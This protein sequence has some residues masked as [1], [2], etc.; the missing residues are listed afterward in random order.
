MSSIVCYT[1]AFVTG[2]YMQYPR[3]DRRACQVSD[4]PPSDHV[5]NYDEPWNRSVILDAVGFSGFGNGVGLSSA[6]WWQWPVD[7]SQGARSCAGLIE[8]YTLDEDGNPNS[9][10]AVK[11]FTA[12]DGV[13][14]GQVNSNDIGFFRIGTYAYGPHV[15]AA[16][17][18]EATPLS[19]ASVDTVTPV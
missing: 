16:S 11:A 10:C 5:E 4:R 1:T 6:V 7:E 12:A 17:R 19:G 18:D 15:L 14:Q 8:G 9:G 2:R 3:D 13:F